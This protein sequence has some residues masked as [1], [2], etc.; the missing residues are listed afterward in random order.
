[1]LAW[2]WQVPSFTGLHVG[3]CEEHGS[4]PAGSDERYAEKQGDVSMKMK[5]PWAAPLPS[6]SRFV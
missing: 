6:A 3:N 1:M 2:K 4:Q 5:E